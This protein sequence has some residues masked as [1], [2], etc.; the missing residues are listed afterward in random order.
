M[1]PCMGCG[2]IELKKAQKG[3][4]FLILLE[5]PTQFLSF[6]NPGLNEPTVFSIS[7]NQKGC[8]F[9]FSFT[10]SAGQRQLF[11]LNCREIAVLVPTL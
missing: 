2:C 11:I 6:V 9:T 3:K 1:K 7:G 8:C 4:E 10:N 5:N